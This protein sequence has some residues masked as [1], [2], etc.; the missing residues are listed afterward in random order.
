MTL[1]VTRYSPGGDLYAAIAAQFGTSWADRAY[2]AARNND[3][4]AALRNVLNDARQSARGLDLARPGSDSTLANF[5]DQIVND[6]LAAPLDSLNDQLG[7]AAWN[8]IRN[9]FVL[10]L[11]AG[12]AAFW[13]WPKL[14]K[15][16]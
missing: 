14:K 10:V 11:V 12:L 5:T 4:G 13:L 16:L 9:P 2:N 6:P 7:K 8:V 3:D 1:D 15:Y